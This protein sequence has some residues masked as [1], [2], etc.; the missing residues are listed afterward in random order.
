MELK[1]RSTS[2]FG[3]AAAGMALSILALAWLEEPAVS[4]HNAWSRLSIR[5]RGA[6]RLCLGLLLI[7]GGGFFMKFV[8][9]RLLLN[10]PLNIG[11]VY[12]VQGVTI[13]LGAALTAW[14]LACA[15]FGL[16]WQALPMP[17]RLLA[18]IVCGLIA[19]SAAIFGA[20]GFGLWDTLTR[21]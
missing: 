4:D 12:L 16:R 13:F 5:Q 3:G 9:A 15:A 11:I 20:A 6:V 21:Y 18:M 17:I 2:G 19:F 14:G 10:H 7:A 8:L 1:S